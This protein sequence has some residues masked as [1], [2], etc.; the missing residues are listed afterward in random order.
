MVHH[1]PIKAYASG[2][3]RETIEDIQVG[4][5]DWVN[6][7]PSL[8]VILLFSILFFKVGFEPQLYQAVCY[9]I[10][11]IITLIYFMKWKLSKKN[12]IE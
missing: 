2:L 12:K 1:K 11:C 5:K 6:K 9:F 4:L 8:I 7:I 3:N 10:V